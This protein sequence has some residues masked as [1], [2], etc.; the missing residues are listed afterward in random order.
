M[1]RWLSFCAPQSSSFL[2]APVSMASPTLFLKEPCQCSPQDAAEVRKIRPAT[3]VLPWVRVR[4]LHTVHHLPQP[5]WFLSSPTYTSPLG[6]TFPCML[7]SPLLETSLLLSQSSF[8]S[9]QLQKGIFVKCSRRV[10]SE[11]KK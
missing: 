9:H 6:S 11:K 5:L 7:L 2:P 1:P 10:L 8:E 4:C 3:R